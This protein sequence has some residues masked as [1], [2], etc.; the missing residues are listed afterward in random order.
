[1]CTLANK[2]CCVNAIWHMQG[3]SESLAVEWVIA[4]LAIIGFVSYRWI[5]GGGAEPN[6]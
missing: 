6:A 5:K 3:K 4:P 2:V 1:M